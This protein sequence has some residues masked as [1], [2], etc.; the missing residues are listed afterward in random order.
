MWG[1]KKNIGFG[2]NFIMSEK[3]G[4]MDFNKFLWVEL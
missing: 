1:R 2:I 4:F 3:C